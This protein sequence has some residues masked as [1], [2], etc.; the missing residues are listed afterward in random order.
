MNSPA[1]DD[2]F[3]GLAAELARSFAEGIDV[4]WDDD[5]FDALARRV[6]AWQVAHNPVYRRFCRDRGRTPDAI[7]DWTGIP[8]VPTTAFKH[9]DLAVGPTEASFRTSGTSRGA[10]AR[11]RHGVRSLALYRAACLPNLAAHLVPEGGPVRI[12][13]LIPDAASVPESS[14]ARMV[15][16]ATEGFDDGGGG[17]FADADGR[18]DLHAFAAAA[19]RAVDEDRTVLVMGTAFAF[20]HWIDAVA[21]GEVGA[22]RLPAGSRVME[23]GGFK[24]R[25]RTVSK[26]VLYDGIAATL[27]VSPAWVV[28]EYGMT[29]LLSQF[30]DG[31]VG[32]ADRGPPAERL[33]RPPPWVRTRVLDPETLGEVPAGVVGV[34]A[35][36]DLA[37]L[38][39]VAAVLTED[40]GVARSDGSFR[41][42][43][44]AAGA[45]PRGCSLA[46]EDLLA[47]RSVAEER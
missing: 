10:D 22:V 1:A 27:G 46:L 38:G 47:A 37:N 30:Y 20:V 36:V 31:V 39:S 4:A 19:A 32:A 26:A 43:G 45:E 40:R 8:L 41:V 25:S 11:G 29:E 28:N 33:H 2:G 21:A 23:T 13:S 16:F 5:R 42:L 6:F 24:G 35:H 12:F 15:A 7:G 17:T 18:L 44:R 3:A 9:V 14:L 34:L